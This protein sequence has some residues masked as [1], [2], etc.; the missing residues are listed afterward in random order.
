MEREK[1]KKLPPPPLIK[2]DL[3][4]LLQPV[5]NAI[6]LEDSI[7][8][9]LYKLIF[10]WI[11]LSLR[12]PFPSVAPRETSAS[13][14]SLCKH[15]Q[16]ALHQTSNSCPPL[17]AASNHQDREEGSAHSSS[18]IQ[19]CKAGNCW[20]ARL[21]HASSLPPGGCWRCTLVS[22]FSP[23]SKKLV[24]AHLDTK[25]YCINFSLQKA[26]SS[27]EER[28]GIP[29]SHRVRLWMNRYIWTAWALIQGGLQ[30]DKLL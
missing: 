29:S 25:L 15:S 4:S 18:C 26:C 27:R 20:L 28:E 16:P 9:T 13:I 24:M 30:N 5:Q 14:H 6:L 10:F 22:T 19:Q 17:T 8:Q 7:T 12:T 21:P 1:G 23:N 2:K 11:H 3:N